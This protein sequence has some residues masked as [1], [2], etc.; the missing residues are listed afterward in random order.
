MSKKRHIIWRNDITERKQGKVVGNGILHF[1]VEKGKQF[2]S[3]SNF[4][5]LSTFLSN[6]LLFVF[7]SPRHLTLPSDRESFFY[8]FV[9]YVSVICVGG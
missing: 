1:H 3:F 4:V 7:A 2:F 5:F 6:G 8:F 9:L